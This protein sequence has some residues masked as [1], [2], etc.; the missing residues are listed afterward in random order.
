[1]RKGYGAI[2]RKIIIIIEI[3]IIIILL[4][5][6]FGERDSMTIGEAETIIEMIEE[7]GEKYYIMTVT[8]YSN[9]SNCITDKWRDGHTATMTPIREGVAAINVD[10]INDKWVVKS[11]LKLGDKIY[12]EGMGNYSVE[13]T[14][15]FAERNHKQDMWTVDIYI[16]DYQNALEFGRQLKKVYVLD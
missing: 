15:K 2:F 16:E 13:D 14:G 1:M 6:T 9:H 7:I 11:P 3:V 12:I 5:M 4:Q 10:Y 8:A